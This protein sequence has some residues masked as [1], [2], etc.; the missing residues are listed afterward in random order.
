MLET[1]A[2][3]RVDFVAL[4]LPGLAPLTASP[5]LLV[6]PPWWHGQLVRGASTGRRHM[7]VLRLR[8]IWAG[9]AAMDASDRRHRG[10]GA[11]LDSG[12]TGSNGGIGE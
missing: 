10:L 11:K 1:I 2:A 4:Y 5:A 8:T 3:P 12:L 6:G 9:R 7:L